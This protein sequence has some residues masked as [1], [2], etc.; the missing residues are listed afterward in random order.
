MATIYIVTDGDYSDYSIYGVFSTKKNAE[1]FRDHCCLGGY[2]EEWGLDFPGPATENKL[3]WKVFLDDDG[4]ILD[5]DSAISD[6]FPRP[7]EI[8]YVRSRFGKAQSRWGA[9]CWATDREHA[10]KIAH[11][12][13]AQNK[14]RR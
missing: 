3:F 10:I 4:N 1:R 12:L 9:Q 5:V 13:W 7:A 6:R 2:I 14:A 8:E 11:D